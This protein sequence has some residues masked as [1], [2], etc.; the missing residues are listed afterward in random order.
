M[1]R[2]MNSAK[3]S[4]NQGCSFSWLGGWELT[5]LKAIKASAKCHFVDFYPHRKPSWTFTF[6]KDVY[7]C[8]DKNKTPQDTV[9]PF[10]VIFRGKVTNQ[11]RKEKARTIRFSA[12][13]GAVPKKR[14][15][16]LQIWPRPNCVPRLKPPSP[17]SQEQTSLSDY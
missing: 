9:Y 8:S 16:K 13:P 6:Q 4:Y 17:F 11:L 12:A 15:T 1:H 7:I 2:R 14:C 3:E 5:C 10:P